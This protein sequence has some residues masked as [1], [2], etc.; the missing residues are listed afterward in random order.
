MNTAAALLLAL[1]GLP[2]LAF[3]AYLLA[4]TLL[5]G[6]P[7]TPPGMASGTARRRHF[8]VIVPAHDEAVV[9]AEVIASL[10]QLDWPADALRIWVIAD[11]CSD[12]TAALARAAGAQ[13]QERRHATRKGKGHA[14]AAAFAASQARG[15][16]DAVVVVDADSTVSTNLLVACSLRLDSG[17]EVVQVYHRVANPQASWRT[18]L[19]AIALSAFHRVRS[20]ARERLGLSCGIRGNGWCVTHKLLR[21]LPYRAYSL[22]EDIEFGIDLGLAGQRVFYADEADV[23]GL[24][25]SGEG[26]ARSQRQRWELGRRELVRSRTGALWHAAWATPARRPAAR[27]KGMKAA[28]TRQAQRRVC[29]DLACDLL[30]PPLAQ[31]LLVVLAFAGLAALALVGL[32]ASPLWLMLALA[33]GVALVLHVLRGWQLSGV[34]LRGLSA[35][36]RAPV[37]VLWKL[38]LGLRPQ[39]DAGWVRTQR[40]QP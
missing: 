27:G 37:F 6:R 33:C 21:T 25:V 12:A 9:I 34:G 31:V 18:C 11:N 2:S 20:R 39:G 19:M 30:L 4:L 16:A 40:E 13:V 28:V 1:L 29:L 24:M 32:D 35:L 3:S 23:A 8:D 10:R 15:W 22:A 38:W 14:L 26:A 17:A 36:L 7:A 5:S